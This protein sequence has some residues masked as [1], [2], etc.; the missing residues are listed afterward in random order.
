MSLKL[1]SSSL[2]FLDQPI[3]PL[4]GMGDSVPW[5]CNAL[6]S[7]LPCSTPKHSAG[8]WGALQQL[9]GSGFLQA[10]NRLSN[11]CMGQNCAPGEDEKGLQ[12]CCLQL[13]WSLCC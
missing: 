5:G 2:P 12:Q 13:G 1:L 7:Q 11:M 6:V 9:G 10:A 8:K 4:C 3:L